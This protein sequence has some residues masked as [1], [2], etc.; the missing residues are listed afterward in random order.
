LR[1]LAGLTEDQ[2][3]ELGTSTYLVKI[4]AAYSQFRNGHPDMRLYTEWA[5]GLAQGLKDQF[6]EEQIWSKTNADYI[7]AKQIQ[8]FGPADDK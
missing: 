1:D 7:R 3:K 5:T 8:Q 4:T 6:D 2:N